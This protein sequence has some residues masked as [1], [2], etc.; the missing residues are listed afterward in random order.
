MWPTDRAEGTYR[1][2]LQALPVI[3]FDGHFINGMV[4]ALQRVVRK[5][6]LV[7]TQRVASRNG[8][9]SEQLNS[10]KKIL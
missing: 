9:D 4:D 8:I 7:H 1:F 5:P 2:E 6:N 10:Y 3:T